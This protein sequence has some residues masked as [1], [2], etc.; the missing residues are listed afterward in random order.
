L[1]INKKFVNFGAK[2]VPKWVPKN[3][4][5]MIFYILLRKEKQRKDGNYP[6][7]LTFRWNGGK[8]Y[9]KTGLC[10]TKKQVAETKEGTLKL[11]DSFLNRLIND[12]TELYNKIVLEMGLSA[13]AYSAPD[14]AKYIIEKA[15]EITAPK[16]TSVNLSLTDFANDYIAKQFELNKRKQLNSLGTAGNMQIAMNSIHRFAKKENLLFDDITVEFLND[17]SHWMLTTQGRE[18]KGVKGRGLQLYLSLLNKLFKEAE[19]VYNNK[20]ERIFLVFNP[21]EDYKIPKPPMPE[22]RA[23]TLE[24]LRR[25]RDYQPVEKGGREE[26]AQDMFL[27]SF[28]LIGMNAVDLY[29]CPPAAGKYI[30]YYRSK[31]KSRRDDKAEFSVLI[32]PETAP[33]LEKYAEKKRLLN[34]SEKYSSVNNFNAALNKG[35][36]VIGNAIGIPNLT[37]YAARHTWATLA[38]NIVGIDKYTVHKC[39]NH[40]DEKMRMTDR[41]TKTDWRPINRA[42]RQVLDFLASGVEV[43]E[44]EF[45]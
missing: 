23:I 45:F 5:V 40:V 39:L 9:I 36:K 14:L 38:E 29:T 35:L 15:N 43:D 13:N 37:F 44:E 20:R 18:R 42:N 34:V 10:A 21:L 19:R 3:R 11:K 41:Y 12:R 1:N 33:L 7:A 31:T 28:Y 17:Y 25:I 22:K 24:Q 16:P 26:L 6:V 32:Q 2:S 27:L 30:T 4:A 8:G